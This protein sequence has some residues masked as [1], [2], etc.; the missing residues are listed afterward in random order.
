ME[1][2]SASAAGEFFHRPIATVGNVAAEGGASG[3]KPFGAAPQL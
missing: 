1:K 3:A 2:R